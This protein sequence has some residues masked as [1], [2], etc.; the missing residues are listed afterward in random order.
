MM[1]FL[2]FPMATLHCTA[3]LYSLQCTAI[4]FQ[5]KICKNI[6][7]PMKIPIIYH[8]GKNSFDNQ[9]F[10]KMSQD[11]I[12]P[13]Q[14]KKIFHFLSISTLIYLIN[15]NSSNHIF[16]SISIFFNFL[17]SKLVYIYYI[18]DKEQ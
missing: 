4:K 14:Y 1:T 10:K 8:V 13:A 11:Y 5:T 7:F 9:I 6:F 15:I 12:Q 16:N 18:V 17:R 3:L 2:S